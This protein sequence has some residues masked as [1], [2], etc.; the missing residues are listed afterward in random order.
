RGTEEAAP[1]RHDRL[2]RAARDRD[3]AQRDVAALVRRERHAPAVGRPARP[4]VIALAVRQLEVVAAARR[5][6]PELVALASEIRAVDDAPAVA[7]PVGVRLPV[8]LLLADERH[9]RSGARL[10]APDA[11]RAPDLAA[12]G[13]EEDLL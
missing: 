11:S 1:L 5:R 12:V 13:D 10:H 7:G 3:D 9:R 6:E 8:R 2:D 4:R